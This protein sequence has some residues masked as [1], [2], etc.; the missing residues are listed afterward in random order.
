MV[1]VRTSDGF[2]EN[3]GTAQQRR[4]FPQVNLANISD[5]AGAAPGNAPI[6]LSTNITLTPVDNRFS[7]NSTDGFGQLLALDTGIDTSRN[8]KFRIGWF[9]EANTAGNVIFRFINT[10]GIDPGENIDNTS[11][12]ETIQFLT[13][14]VGTSQSGIV[15]IS[16]FT[17][18]LPR[19]NDEAFWAYSLARIGGATADTFGGNI[20]IAFIE[21]SGYWWR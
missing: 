20:A 3:F 7:S 16:E 12:I 10:Q 17:F 15:R 8:M 19:T 6:A 9:P 21:A 2:I 11:V 4:V 13:A 1:S 18:K 5:L 14:S